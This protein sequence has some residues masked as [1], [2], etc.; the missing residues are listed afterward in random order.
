MTPNIKHI[1][2]GNATV[3]ITNDICL[4]YIANGPSSINVEQSIKTRHEYE[5]EYFP[6]EFNHPKPMDTTLFDGSVA[7]R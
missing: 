6:I 7:F 1:V 5:K 2:P 3:F 4:K